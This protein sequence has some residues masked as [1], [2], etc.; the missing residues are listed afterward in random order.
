PKN[1]FVP[2]HFTNDIIFV[3]ACNVY[4]SLMMK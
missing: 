2:L 4:L 1:R 3:M